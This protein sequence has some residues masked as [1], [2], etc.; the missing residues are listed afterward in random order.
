M[1]FACIFPGQGSQIVGMGLDLYETF[2]ASRAVFDH[3]DD[4]LG[5]SLSTICFNGPPEKLANTAVQQ[6]A[7]LTTSLAALRALET[8]DALGE[9]GVAAA[10]G[11]SL[12]E[13]SALVFAGVIALEDA[14]RLVA[15]RGELMDQAGRARPGGM[16]SVLGLERETVEAICRDAAGG[17]TLVIANLNCAGQVVVSGDRAAIERAEPLAIERGAARAVVLQVS[18]AFHS[19]LMA[20]AQQG[21]AEALSD[22]AFSAPR[23]PFI[24]NVTGAFENDPDRIKELL[25]EQLGSPVLWQASME[26]LLADGVTRF[27]E[28]GPGVVLRGLLRRIDRV[29]RC[30]CVG[31]AEA[32]RKRIDALRAGERVGD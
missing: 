6:P 10:C 22:V 4:A 15:R 29:A 8:S 16:L 14:V 28:I 13:Y 30:E 12:G 11:L 32:V 26:R 7:I 3:A 20:P 17:D 2:D 24:S 27:V 31:T 25:V 9:D 21:L 18:G 19:S 5:Y 1:S 23:V